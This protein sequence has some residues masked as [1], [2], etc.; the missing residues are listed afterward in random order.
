MDA[1]EQTTSFQLGVVEW[2]LDLFTIYQHAKN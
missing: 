2:S 1:G